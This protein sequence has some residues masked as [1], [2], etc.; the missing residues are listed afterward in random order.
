M[1][2]TNPVPGYKPGQL[3]NGNDSREAPRFHQEYRGFPLAALPSGGRF[4][5]C[6]AVQAPH[7]H[8]AIDYPA[9]QGAKIVAGERS[10][11]IQF[12]TASD[13]AKYVKLRINAKAVLEEWHLSAFR[14]GMYVG[15]IIPKGGLVGYVGHTGNASGNHCH[16]VL[17][18]TDKDPDGVVRTYLYDPLLFTLNNGS[19]VYPYLA[20]DSRIQPAY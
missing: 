16:H 4:P 2:L 9:P 13:G 7:Y 18:I 20:S 12:G 11:V 15:M 19:S 14:A 5:G 10:K 8:G 17:K 3:F 1:A 6:D